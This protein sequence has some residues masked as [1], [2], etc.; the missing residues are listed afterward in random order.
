MTPDLRDLVEKDLE[1]AIRMVDGE[2]RGAVILALM[3]GRIARQL[4]RIAKA[5][6]NAQILEK[7]PEPPS[8]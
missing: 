5:L 1:T 6:E 7:K 8:C 4:E 3:L 2:D